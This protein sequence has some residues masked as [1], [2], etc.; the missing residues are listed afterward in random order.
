VTYV[1][2][3]AGLKSGVTKDYSLV[4]S[5]AEKWFN[6]MGSSSIVGFAFNTAILPELQVI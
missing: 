6:A 2:L 1:D 4:G 5:T 3:A